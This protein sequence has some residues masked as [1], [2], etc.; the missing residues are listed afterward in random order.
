VLEYRGRGNALFR[1]ALQ[2]T[3][4]PHCSMV[5]ERVAMACS[6]EGGARKVEVVVSIW[7]P[8][9]SQICVGS[10]WHFLGLRPSLRRSSRAATRSRSNRSASLLSAKKSRPCTGVT[11]LPSTASFADSVGT[12]SVALAA[13]P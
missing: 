6:F 11:E 10:H 9:Y 3:C 1:R 13:S 12:V 2:D 8:E 7:S 4:I 5:R